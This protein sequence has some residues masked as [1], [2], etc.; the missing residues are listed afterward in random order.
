MGEEIIVYRVL[1][2]KP[3]GKRPEDQGIDGIRMDLRETGWD[4]VEWVQLAQDRDRWQPLV[5][6]V[7]NFRVLAP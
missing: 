2:G 4:S 7:M 6:T 5:N 1:V 3:E